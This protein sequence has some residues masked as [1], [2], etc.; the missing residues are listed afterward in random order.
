MCLTLKSSKV[1]VHTAT[2][3]IVCY[4][5]LQMQYDMFH[6]PIGYVTYYQRA[7]VN[8]GETYTSKLVR[9]NYHLSNIR[10]DIG[11]GLHSFRTLERAKQLWFGT[12]T[13]IAKC[14]IPAGSK[15]YVGRFDR[16]DDYRESYASDRLKYVEILE[17]S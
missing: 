14:I 2:K 1:R 7:R 3:D 16:T 15:Y 5:I 8:I 11:E 12:S 13:R 17:F 9:F 4:K 10:P 6:N